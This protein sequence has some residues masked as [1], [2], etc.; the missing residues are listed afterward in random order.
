MLNT[1]HCLQKALVPDATG[2]EDTT[3]D[4]L[5]DK[6]FATHAGCYVD[7]GLCTLPPTD[8]L[9]VV[10]IVQLRTLFQNWDA[11]KATVKAGEGCLK[12]WAFLV[13]QNFF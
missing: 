13:K 8:W 7:S 9:A 2:A 1:M 11:F 12:F 5:E 4:A 3:C 6:A 10:E